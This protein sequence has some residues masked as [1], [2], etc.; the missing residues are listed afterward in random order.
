MIRFSRFVA[1]VA[2]LLVTAN[3]RADDPKEKTEA[4]VEKKAKSK[5][6]DTYGLELKLGLGSYNS[7]NVAGEGDE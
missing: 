2:C 7:I 5:S 4:K 6:F 3:A 1:L